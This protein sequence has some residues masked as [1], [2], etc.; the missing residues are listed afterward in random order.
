MTAPD[1]TRT[2]RIL[3]GTAFT[4]A[5]IAHVVKHEFF[6]NLVPDSLARWRKSIS[7]ATAVI[8]F[9]GGISMFVP[10][11]RVL[12]RWTNLAM[13]VPTLPAAVAQTRH[14][15]HVRPRRESQ[16]RHR[17]HPGTTAGG[18]RD[19]VGNPPTSQRPPLTAHS[20]V[21]PSP[22]ER[23]P[24]GVGMVRTLLELSRARCRDRVAVA[25]VL[26]QHVS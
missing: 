1:P 3:L 24:T 14:P 2:T 6:E 17:P 25:V 16:T 10:R 8:Q 12:A 26:H 4:G 7:A 20:V 5:G 19:L 15:D 11:L 13:L 22:T 18:H 9:V 21:T 23:S